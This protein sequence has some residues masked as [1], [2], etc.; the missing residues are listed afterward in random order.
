MYKRQVYCYAGRGGSDPSRRRLYSDDTELLWGAVMPR[1][2][3]V[4]LKGRG[5]GRVDDYIG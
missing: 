2:R 1:D 3:I 4:D 5:T